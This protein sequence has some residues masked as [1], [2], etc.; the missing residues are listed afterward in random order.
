VRGNNCDFVGGTDVGAA[1]AA[2]SFGGFSFAITGEDFNFLIRAL[3]SD[4]VLEV[5]S[6]PNITVANNQE[7]NITIGDRV[8]FLRGSNISD[9]G[10]VNSTVE[11]EDIGIQL[12]VTPHINPDGYV[13]LEIRPEIS[14]LNT[15]S[16]VQISEGLTAPTFANRSAETVVTVKDGETVVIGGLIQTTE[17]DRET[18]VPIFGDLPYLGT[19]F[20]A[21]SHSNRRTELLLVLTVNVIRDEHD[22]YEQSV[23]LRDQS[24][25]LPD[26]TK[27]SPLMGRLRIL[28]DEKSEAED[29]SGMEGSRTPI[30]TVP[31]KR[32]RDLYR[33][34][35][36][37]Y[38]PSRPRQV[39][40]PRGPAR[41]TYGPPRPN[42]SA[43]KV[44][45]QASQ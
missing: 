8:P 27:S 23:R 41:E 15:G 25:F 36:D 31:R 13:N 1:G 45:M 12:D 26:S 22:A 11:Y 16:N 3:K 34:S 19:L 21:T 28:P 20:R 44:A 18:K 10:Q 42:R 43:E 29:G 14:S 9:S 35:P 4:G 6:R 39:D 38:G 7:A 40:P 2:G 24:G 37:V 33:P 32:D 17:D 30:R 5:L